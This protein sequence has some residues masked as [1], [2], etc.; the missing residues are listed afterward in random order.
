[1]GKEAMNTTETVLVW[2]VNADHQPPH[3]LSEVLDILADVEG[4]IPIEFR[5]S[6]RIDFE[7]Y[8]EFG[9]YYPQ[10]TVTYERPMTPAEMAQHAAEEAEHWESQLRTAEER[11]AYCRARLVPSP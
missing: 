7:P 11:V 8:S 4:D 10:V 2:G 9:E 6:A 3:R 5:E 1:M